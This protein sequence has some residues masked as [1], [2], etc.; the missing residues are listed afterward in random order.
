MWLR[1]R[2]RAQTPG[3]P[4]PSAAEMFASRIFAF[5]D[6]QARAACRER[7]MHTDEWL[8]P[9]R[10][11]E[12]ELQ[13][14]DGIAGCSSEVLAIISAVTDL[15]RYKYD[16]TSGI[17]HDASEDEAIDRRAAELEEKLKTLKQWTPDSSIVCTGID[18]PPKYVTQVQGQPRCPADIVLLAAEAKRQAA[19]LF[20]ACA[21]HGTSPAHRTSIAHLVPAVLS[22]IALIPEQNMRLGLLWPLFI[23]GCECRDEVDRRFVLDRFQTLADVVGTGNIT[24]AKSVVEAVW[25][26]RD[27]VNESGK[28]AED[29]SWGAVV[30]VL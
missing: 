25:R 26:K 21:F 11:G 19:L 16:R 24:R 5:L 13:R 7:A 10:F 14:V 27:I 20:L 18:P 2:S 28:K 30:S 9:T 8:A 1:A 6:I 23:V 17:L 29:D 12:K 4:L 22:T 15:A 3:A